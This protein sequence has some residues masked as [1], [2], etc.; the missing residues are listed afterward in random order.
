MS[1]P[2]RKE[3][4][5]LSD[6]LD[7]LQAVANEGGGV[8]C[9]LDLLRR[10]RK[11]VCVAAESTGDNATGHGDGDDE[12]FKVDLTKVPVDVNKVGFVVSFSGAKKRRQSFGQPTIAFL[13]IINQSDGTQLF[14]VYPDRKSA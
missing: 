12:T 9:V 11:S 8:S 1:R 6:N 3:A 14:R 7:A 10:N 4:K 13:S 2:D 5:E